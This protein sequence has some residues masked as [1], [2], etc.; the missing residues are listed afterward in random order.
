M[1]N[2]HETEFED[3]SLNFD[4][5]EEPASTDEDAPM[6]ESFEDAVKE[7]V[8]DFL[9]AFRQRAKDEEAQKAKNVSTDYWFAVYFASQEQR[10][11]FL[12]A[13]SLIEKMD[14][15]YIDGMTFAKAVGVEIPKEEIII[16][17]SFR[18]PADIDD[19]VMDI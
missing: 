8:S 11:T 6:P 5:D 12:R 2:S 10:D 4:M 18:R 14:D 16:P 1:K 7:E 9:A 3:I 15:Q 13:L 19:L 17:K